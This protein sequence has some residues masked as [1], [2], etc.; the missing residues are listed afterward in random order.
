MNYGFEKLHFEEIIGL[1]E[2]ENYASI[3]VLEKVGMQFSETVR[4]FGRE[5]RRYVI[6]PDLSDPAI[7]LVSAVLA[8]ASAFTWIVT[9]KVAPLFSP[10]VPAS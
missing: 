9:E 6:R 5:M 1:S 7:P 8:A 4:L 2:P 3:R 10:A